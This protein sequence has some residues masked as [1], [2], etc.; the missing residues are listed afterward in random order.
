MDPVTASVSELYSYQ[1][2]RER[3]GLTE[4]AKLWEDSRPA[5]GEYLAACRRRVQSHLPNEGESLLDFAS[6]PI[7]YPEYLEYSRDF[8]TRTC[9]DLSEHALVEAKKKLGTKGEYLHGDFLSIPIPADTFAC[10]ISLHTIYHIDAQ[11]QE[12]AVRKLID[13]TKKGCSIVI[14]YSNPQ[15]VVSVPFK[16]WGWLR[17]RLPCPP[18]DSPLYFHAFP[19]KWWRRFE[20]QAT[21]VQLPWR[22]L[23]GSTLRRLIPNNILGTNV[24]RGLFLLEE[25]FPALFLALG[26]YPMIILTKK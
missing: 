3:D 19:L 21:M 4:D 24:L 12:I 25:K 17:K 16:V 15:N 13:V 26:E 5:I 23:S 7:Q 1:L 10:S 11:K 20:D 22:T 9:V 8:S 18:P 2:W 14:V 6:G